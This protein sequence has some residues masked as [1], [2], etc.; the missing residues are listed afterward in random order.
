MGR[1]KKPSRIIEYRVVKLLDEPSLPYMRIFQVEETREGIKIIK[2][3]CPFGYN[4]AELHRDI[5]EILSAFNKPSLIY[6][7]ENNEFVE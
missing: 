1:K 2:P 3:A 6:D 4:E 7:L 5:L